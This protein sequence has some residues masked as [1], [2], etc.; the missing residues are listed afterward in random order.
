MWQPWNCLDLLEMAT[1]GNRTVVHTG[2][3]A[4]TQLLQRRGDPFLDPMKTN[5]TL[6][7]S[8]FCFPLVSKPPQQKKA[9]AGLCTQSLKNTNIAG[10]SDIANCHMGLSQFPIW[11]W[12]HN[13]IIQDKDH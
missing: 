13:L 2:P 12:P 11:S 4:L 3:P 9:V 6:L 5:N 7:P 10:P 8:S 1:Y